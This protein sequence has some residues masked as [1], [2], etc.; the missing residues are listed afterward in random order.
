MAT[1]LAIA[2]SGIRQTSAVVKGG[3]L[4]NSATLLVRLRLRFLFENNDVLPGHDVARARMLHLWERRHFFQHLLF[5]HLVHEL[6]GHLL[7]FHAELDEDH[8]S[9]RL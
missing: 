8:P 6:D 4:A 9:P 5:A 7:V 3:I 1:A 2:C